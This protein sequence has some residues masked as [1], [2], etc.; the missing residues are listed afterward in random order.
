[1]VDKYI[2]DDEQIEVYEPYLQTGQDR[3]ICDRC[4]DGCTGVSDK[5]FAFDFNEACDVHDACYR[6]N[7]DLT[8]KQADQLF[9]ALMCQIV[10]KQAKNPHHQ[11]LG[12][13][14]AYWRYNVVRITGTLFWR[15][16]GNNSIY[17]RCLKYW[18]KL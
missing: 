18:K 5:I 11:M 15:P 12:Y 17:E 9:F 1:M 7:I 8:R 2:V 3:E 13:L 16:N 6:N 10:T 4:Y 14:A